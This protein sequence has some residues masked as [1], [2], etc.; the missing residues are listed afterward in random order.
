MKGVRN[1]PIQEKLAYT[2]HHHFLT[3]YFDKDRVIVMMRDSGKLN[4]KAGQADATIIVS[5]KFLRLIA[6]VCPHYVE[7]RD[8]W[9]SQMND[10]GDGPS[11]A[12][13]KLPPKLFPPPYSV[14]PPP[15]LPP[16]PPPVPR[17][18]DPNT[19]CG[20]RFM[21]LEEQI[22]DRLTM[23]GLLS[24]MCPRPDP[25]VFKMIVR[26]FVGE[27]HNLFEQNDVSL[28]SDLICQGDWNV[29]IP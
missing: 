15:P 29:L 21:D 12:S 3:T 9:F 14:P 17:T 24:T 27:N 20:L 5:E 11:S 8:T 16:P 13:R 6:K 18:T 26:M 22:Y 23:F 19:F 28:S 1:F 4:V 25:E 2:A 7:T 10:E